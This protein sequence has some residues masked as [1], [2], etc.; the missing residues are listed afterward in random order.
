[1]TK[2]RA[3]EEQAKRGRGRPPKEQLSMA[4]DLATALEYVATAAK[5]IRWPSA[6]Y[7]QDPERYFV[8]ILG[9]RPWSRQLEVLEAIRDYPRVAVRA[10]HKVSKSHTIA[11]VALWYYCSFDDARAILTSTTARQV[12]QKIGRAHV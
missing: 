4:G 10:G 6:R 1:M 5:S 2:P 7:Q 11:G 8:E 9:V 12:D 3:Q